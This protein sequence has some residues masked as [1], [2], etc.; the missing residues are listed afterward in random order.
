MIMRFQRLP[1][2]DLESTLNSTMRFMTRKYNFG[3][4]SGLRGPRNRPK[5]KN[6][7][8]QIFF[9]PDF[10]QPRLFSA[11]TFFQPRLFP[12]PQ[13]FFSAQ[14]SDFFRKSS[15]LKISLFSVANSFSIPPAGF[16]EI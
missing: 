13:T 11:Q 8:L 10:F 9:S 15:R 1:R 5:V 14:S 4:Y 6:L 12:P 7:Q 2:T 3:Y 16:I